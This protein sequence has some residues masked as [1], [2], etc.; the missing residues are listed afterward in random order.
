[1]LAACKT[2]LYR[3]DAF[4]IFD[5]FDAFFSVIQNSDGLAT[6][7][8]ERAFDLLFVTIEKLTNQLLKFLDDSN[9]QAEGGRSRN[10]Y[11]NL[12]S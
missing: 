7:Q 11:L 2:A 10:E 6:I 5:H 3:A 9:G 8:L 4:Y 12:V 1:M